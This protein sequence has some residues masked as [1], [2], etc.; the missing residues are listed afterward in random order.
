MLRGQTVAS[1]P[2]CLGDVALLDQPPDRVGQRHLDVARGHAQVRLGVS[3]VGPGRAPVQIDALELYRDV[4]R[5]D[6]LEELDRP[7]ARLAAA[8]RPAR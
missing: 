2:A 4:D 3:V 8:A 5:H 6:A 1:W 7:P